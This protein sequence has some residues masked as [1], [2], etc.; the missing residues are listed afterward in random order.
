MTEWPPARVKPSPRLAL[1][2]RNVFWRSTLAVF[3]CGLGVVPPDTARTATTAL[4]SAVFPSFLIVFVET[5][6]TIGTM[7][8]CGVGARSRAGVRLVICGSTI[9]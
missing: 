7:E 3:G 5:F 2:R 6:P 8:S 1:E 9:E 4:S